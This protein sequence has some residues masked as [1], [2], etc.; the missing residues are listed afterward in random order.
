MLAIHLIAIGSVVILFLV[1]TMIATGHEEY[2]EVK[3]DL[4]NKFSED[5][6]YTID[7]MKDLTPN[8]ADRKIDE[9]ENKWSYVIGSH[10]MKT[11]VGR[12]IDAQYRYTVS[13]S[14]N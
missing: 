11:A 10:Q 2:T 6:D 14:H 7:L 5:L 4:Y 1:L 8:E 9:F 12:L 3:T 13:N